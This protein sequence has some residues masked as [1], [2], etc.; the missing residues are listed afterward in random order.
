MTTKASDL[1]T[2]IAGQRERLSE[3]V[4]TLAEKIGEIDTHDLRARAESGA[5]DLLENV[6]DAEGNPKRGLVLGA[7]AVLVALV[8]LRKLFR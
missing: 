7:V 6:T 5:A 3:S 8:L 2:Q 4:G 1:G